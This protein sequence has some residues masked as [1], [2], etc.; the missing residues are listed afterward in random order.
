MEPIATTPLPQ[1]PQWDIDRRLERLIGQEVRVAGESFVPVCWNGQVR[2]S[3]IHV[4]DLILPDNTKPGVLPVFFEGRLCRFERR[5]GV[6]CVAL[7]LPRVMGRAAEGTVLVRGIP[8]V[9]LR[10]PAIVRLAFPFRVEPLP[11]DEANY[12]EDLRL[13]TAQ[14]RLPFDSASETVLYP[15]SKECR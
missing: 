5:I 8:A 10:G 9:L 2:Q 4:R 6:V 14:F 11:A 12:W 3:F 13:P 7:D 15:A 1:R